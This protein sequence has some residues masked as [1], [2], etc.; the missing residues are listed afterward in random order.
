MNFVDLFWG[1]WKIS[2]ARYVGLVCKEAE[3]QMRVRI[4]YNVWP[5]QHNVT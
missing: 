3:K 4:T 5:R 2:L 1:I